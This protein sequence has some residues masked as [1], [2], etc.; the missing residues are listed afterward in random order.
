MNHIIYCPLCDNQLKLSGITR[1]TKEPVYICKPCDL[2]HIIRSHKIYHKGY[3][4]ET[5]R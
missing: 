3:T 1:A 5:Q 2:K 4:I